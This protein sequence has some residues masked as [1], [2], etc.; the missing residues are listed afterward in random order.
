[1]PATVPLGTWATSTSEECIVEADSFTHLSGE[2]N[3]EDKVW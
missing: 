1:M 2:K 3:I